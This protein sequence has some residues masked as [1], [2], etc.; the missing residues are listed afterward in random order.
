MAKNPKYHMGQKV[1][2][3]RGPG[4]AMEAERANIGHEGHVVGIHKF[5]G[6][7]HHY[8]VVFGHRWEDSAD[9]SCLERA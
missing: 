1:R 2:A 9:E 8:T 3:V 6:A 5:H 7:E 4:G